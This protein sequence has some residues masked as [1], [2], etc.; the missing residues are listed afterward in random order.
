MDSDNA[1][2]DIDNGNEVP[3]LAVVRYAVTY[4]NSS[5]RALLGTYNVEA[6]QRASSTNVSNI[7]EALSIANNKAL[8]DVAVWIENQTDKPQS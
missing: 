5:N 4:A 7:V 2:F 6:V 1:K 3:P 8:T